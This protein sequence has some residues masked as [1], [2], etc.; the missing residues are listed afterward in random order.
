M[1]SKD[2]KLKLFIFSFSLCLSKNFKV[3]TD[4]FMKDI[5]DVQG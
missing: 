4:I 3:D 5:E 1:Y 2:N